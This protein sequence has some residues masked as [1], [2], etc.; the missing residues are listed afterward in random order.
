[1]LFKFLAFFPL[2]ILFSLCTPSLEDLINFISLQI[3]TPQ[4]SQ[5]CFTVFSEVQGNSAN[6]SAQEAAEMGFYSLTE[7]ADGKDGMWSF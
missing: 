1:M 6:K 5:C 4:A 3:L 2:N 7:E